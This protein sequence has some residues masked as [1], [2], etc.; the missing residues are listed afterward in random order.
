M[1]KP[2]ICTSS[3]CDN[4]GCDYCPRCSH[5]IYRGSAT[6][7]RRKY[8][9]EFEPMF[10]VNFKRKNKYDWIP[11]Q[12]HKAWK[13]FEKWLKIFYRENEKMNIEERKQQIKE[14]GK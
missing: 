5:A 7:D 8:E 11:A 3:H 13:A 1:R 4:L 12:R 2:T 14:G 10:G 9:F 6:I